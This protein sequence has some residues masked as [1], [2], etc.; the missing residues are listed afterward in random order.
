MPLPK[1]SVLMP[2]FNHADYIEAAVESVL[3]QSLNDLELI[4]IDDASADETWLKLQRYASDPRVIL[5]RHQQNQGAHSTLNE[6]LEYARGDIITIINSDDIFLPDRLQQCC[7]LIDKG[8]DF[9]GSDI[10]LI[11]AQG[12]NIYEHWWVDA[13]T[14]LKA[15][16]AQHADWVSALLAGNM[17]MT[18]SNFV[19]NRSVFDK[20]GGFNNYRYVLDYEYLLRVLA[21][22]FNIQW[23]D[24]KL[25]NY[26]LHE[27]NTITDSPLKANQECASL[28]RAQASVLLGGQDDPLYKVRWHYLSL[29]WARVERYIIEI[30]LEQK[31]HE[32]VA[33]ENN[34]RKDVDLRDCRVSERDSWLEDCNNNLSI[35]DANIEQLNTMLSNYR[36]SL[37]PIL[38]IIGW[39]GSTALASAAR[40][41]KV[42]VKPFMKPKAK[43]RRLFSLD[44]KLHHSP[45]RVHDL[46]GL[47]QWLELRL[48]TIQ[49][50][51]FDIFDT[52]ITRC[53]EPPE[54]LHK[55][56]ADEVAQYLG[57]QVSAETALALR[58][59]EERQ[60]REASLSNGGDHECHYDQL[61]LGWARRL[62]GEDRRDLIDFIQAK[63]QELEH[64]A[65]SAKPGAIELLEHLKTRGVRIIA[66]SDMYFSH[67]HIQNILDSCGF[68]GL[69]QNIY[70]SADFALAKYSGRL[71]A[72]VLEAEGLSAKQVVHIG[73]NLVSDMLSPCSLGIQGVFL[74]ERK[75][76][77]RRR[78]QKLS[79]EM[80]GQGGI[81]PGRMLNEI[82]NERL[83]GEAVST[84]SPDY[85]ELGLTVLGPLFSTFTLGLVE[86]LMSTKPEKIYF[87]ARDGYVF[88]Q[89]YE[90]YLA[91]SKDSA[92]LP[93]PHYL[94]VSRRVLSSAAIAD[95]LTL[96][97]AK[98]AFYNPKQQG[99]LSICKTY[100]L[101]PEPFKSLSEQ[102][103]IV[104][105]DAPM[106]DWDD[107]RLLTFLDDERV[108]ALARTSGLEA[109]TLLKDYLE[110]EGFF[111]S[112]SAAFVDIGWNGTIQKFLVETFGNEPGFP[113]LHGYYY[114]LGTDLHGEFNH[115]G[116]IE[117]LLMDT[118]HNNPCERA[119][120]DFE[121]LFEQGA[122]ALEATTLA[123]SRTAKGI[124]PVLKPDSAADR[125]N[126]LACNPSVIAMQQG[127]QHYFQHFIAAQQLTG[128]GFQQLR[129]YALAIAER[130]VVY[131]DRQEAASL[132]QLA[133]TED[134]GHDEI[135]NLRVRFVKV[136]HLLHPRA[137]YQQLRSAPWRYGPLAGFASPWSAWLARVVH[138][139]QAEGKRNG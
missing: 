52:L 44:K 130:A 111:Q 91:F 37:D 66:V 58:Y 100:G 22:G 87:L 93:K 15:V 137:V 132:G 33:Q 109:R 14:E 43:I 92:T 28:L 131:P 134:F 34:W 12:S 116:S 41:L 128:F 113:R 24:C 26:R 64:L 5:Y 62:V 10:Q 114:A 8:A 71:L 125:R 121:E 59:T 70:V 9:V 78:H 7:D 89:F 97:Q 29:Q 51:S 69:L 60:L 133:H 13:F 49:C 54:W 108:Q 36:N 117:G 72:K 50:V 56:V 101:D 85:F 126:E 112:Q 105:F 32:L 1:I 129:P 3:E 99:I 25:L 135:L 68:S 122:R 94:Y 123:Y 119:P 39:R 102:H 118:R 84:A 80:V 46:T 103:G 20:I 110:Q 124:E 47:K 40:V 77:I 19:F 23:L 21:S 30:L 88:K 79:A 6:A 42:L 83:Q 17:F 139:K 65:L 63:E 75:E 67:E 76:R 98:V 57:G 90:Q 81:W 136:K 73:D 107:P 35:R 96:Q 127:A 61:V 31:H 38:S 48:D 53:I 115:G 18:T 4:V 55:R 2:A 138:L 104:T 45:A 27:R 86:R 74:D 82:V 16:Y 106:T 95:G 120:S 11:D